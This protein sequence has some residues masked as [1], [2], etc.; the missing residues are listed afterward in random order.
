MTYFMSTEN[1][2]IHSF[3]YFY[4][5]FNIFLYKADATLYGVSFSQATLRIK[6]TGLSE[7]SHM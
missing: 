5:D 7:I 6:V 4:N 3:N 2:V 1:P